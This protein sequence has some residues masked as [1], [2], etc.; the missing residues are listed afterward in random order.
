[1]FLGFTKLLVTAWHHEPAVI[2][3][4]NVLYVNAALQYSSVLI[5]AYG[6]LNPS[7]VIVVPFP[8]R[9]NE[10]NSGQGKYLF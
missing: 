4:S 9:P 7:K 6:V 10:I 2:P 3:A 1:M 8:F 5:Q